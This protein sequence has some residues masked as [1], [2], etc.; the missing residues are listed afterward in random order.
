MYP[1]LYDQSLD[2]P[3]PPPPPLDDKTCEEIENFVK[4]GAEAYRN[5]KRIE[6]EMRQMNQQEQNP[7]M[8]WT[9]LMKKEKDIIFYFY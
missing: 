4:T 2:R 7:R 5:E 6:E 8:T 3:G 9:E 1:D